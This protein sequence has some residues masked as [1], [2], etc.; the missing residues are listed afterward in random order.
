MLW[1]ENKV[2]WCQDFTDSIEDAYKKREIINLFEGLL[3]FRGFR[4]KPSNMEQ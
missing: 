1:N 2:I 4:Y 3:P